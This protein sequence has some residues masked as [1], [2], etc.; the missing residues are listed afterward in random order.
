MET[1]TQLGVR[2]RW[3][4]TGLLGIGL[5]I[6]AIN[7]STTNFIL[8]Q[9][10]TSLRVELYQIHWVITAFGIA[11][12]VTIPAL[13]WLSGWLGPRKLYLASLGLF[14]L[15]TLG[16][17]VAWDWPSLLF[18]RIVAGAGG[19]LIPPLSMAIFYQ[20]FPPHQRGMALG[21]S[22]MGWSIGPTVGPL[23][24]GYLLDF[25]S[26]RAIYVMMLP[27]GV[28]GFL[29]A[30]WLL[31][32]LRAPERRRLDHYGLLSMAV[33]VTSLLLALTQGN[34]QGWDSQQVL[35]SFAIAAGAGLI[36]VVIELCHPQPLVEL[37]LFR[38]V[39]FVL[40]TLVMMLT[41]MAFRSTGPMI[42]ILL[43]RLLDLEPLNIAWVMLPANV[44]Y[45]VAVI[46]VGR[47]SDRVSPQLLVSGGLLLYG[48]TFLAYAGVNEVTT[49]AMMM[50]FLICRFVA[51]GFIVSP[52]NYTALQ[53]LPD[54]QV[55]MASG[56]LGLARSIANT[57]GPA[58]AA[59]VWD[60]R[61]VM[62][63][64]HYAEETP[65]DAIGF[66]T[67]LSRLQQMLHWSG[68]LPTQIPLQALTLMRN[69][70]FAIAST[71][72]W[73]DYFLCNTLLALLSLGFTLLLWRRS[74]SSARLHTSATDTS[75]PRTP[76]RV[77]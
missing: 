14:C 74:R 2:D 24:G 50:T 63:M 26:W 54:S 12:T 18:F 66:T 1:T 60:Q 62:H 69:R 11:R 51:E 47:L 21:F 75:K 72:A 39:S 28:L 61:Y 68:E 36:F 67:T 13:G 6:F 44:I 45:G 56:L 29:M 30:W 46:I 57:L 64:R 5:I 34:R 16:S 35:T 59:V 43:R 70:L 40:A 48:G 17:A 31:P 73:Q 53:A 65:L 25:A 15:G 10:M 71:A 19:G 49:M 3:L 52:N 8:P 76:A 77:T 55:M 23:M 22:L 37:R 9:L 42:P 27:F 4:T 33:A 38:N 41:T 7:G 32:Q 58:L 20:I